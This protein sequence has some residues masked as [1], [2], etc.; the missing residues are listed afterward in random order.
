MNMIA[1]TKVA[2]VAAALVGS[3]MLATDADAHGRFR[4]RSHVGIY[5]GVPGPFYYRPYYPRYYYAPA[6]VVPAPSPV[7]YPPPA[8]YPPS[9]STYIEQSPPPSAAPAAAA[10]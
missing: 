10:S 9:P 4:H 6:V 5:F 3:S 1:A 2:I 7:Y 8:Y